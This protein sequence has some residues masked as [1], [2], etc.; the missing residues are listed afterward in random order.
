[1]II[2][3]YAAMGLMTFMY[4]CLFS[5]ALII[6][7]SQK[8]SIII[9]YFYIVYYIRIVQTAIE[10]NTF[11]DNESKFGLNYLILLMGN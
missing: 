6:L 3:H 9:L 11:I 5:H 10:I 8:V 1:M 2:S 4:F 7:A